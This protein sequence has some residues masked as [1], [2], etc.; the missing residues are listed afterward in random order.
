MSLGDR[1]AFEIPAAAPA[2]SDPVALSVPAQSDLVIS[3]HLP[4]RTSATT[5][6]GSAFQR[7]FIAA[8]NVTRAAELPGATETTSRYFLSGVSV[9]ASSRAASIVALGDSIT[10]DRKSV[11]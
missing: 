10:E 6:H 2:L 4:Q 9:S 3:I 7:N 8:G 5:L 1:R 11:G